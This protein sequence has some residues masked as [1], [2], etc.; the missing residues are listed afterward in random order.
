[1]SSLS[2]S[3]SA[4]AFFTP[5]LSG[6]YSVTAGLSRLAAGESILLSDRETPRYL[7]TKRRQYEACREAYVQYHDMTSTLHDAA[8]ERL[9]PLLPGRVESLEEAA[10]SIPDDLAIVTRN[11]DGGDHLAALLVFFPNGWSA[12]EKI[13]K[14]FFQVHMPVAQFAAINA[15]A[16]QFVNLMVSTPEPLHRFVWGIRFDDYLDHRLPHE[17]PPAPAEAFD[18]RSPRVYVR[19]ERQVILSMPKVQSAIFLIRTFLYD[20]AQLPKETLP[21]LIQA[22]E[23]MHPES[24]EYKGLTAAVPT[25]LPWL[26]GLI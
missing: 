14:S 5:W 24:V 3:I 25:L 19:V 17:E 4:P 1:M 10:L 16:T 22:L 23:T 26:R 2:S 15:K 11:A 13:G 7:E 20:V 6:R 9:R 8:V 21:P 18:P 12:R